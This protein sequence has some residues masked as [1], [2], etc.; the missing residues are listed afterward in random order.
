MGIIKCLLSK[1][2]RFS[3]STALSDAYTN[4]RFAHFLY[5]RHF[6]ETTKTTFNLLPALAN[7]RIDQLIMINHCH[8]HISM[9]SLKV[10]PKNTTNAI[11]H[12]NDQIIT[13]KK[14]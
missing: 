5:K 13:N 10:L 4:L 2:K 8:M 11:P 9:F 6:H 7:I 14:D 12:I 1:Q 3:N